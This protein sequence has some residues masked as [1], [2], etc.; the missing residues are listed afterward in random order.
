MWPPPTCPPCPDNKY[1][2]QQCTT[3]PRHTGK[4]LL[5]S[6][7][8]P[9]ILPSNLLRLCHCWV[10]LATL[11]FGVHHFF[12]AK[13]FLSYAICWPSDALTPCICFPNSCLSCRPA[14]CASVLT[15]S[16]FHGL[17]TAPSKEQGGFHNWQIFQKISQKQ[18]VCVGARCCS[19]SAKSYLSIL[20]T[21]NL[22]LDINLFQLFTGWQNKH[23][24]PVR[25]AVWNLSRARRQI[26]LST[27]PPLPLTRA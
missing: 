3:S 17:C 1:H 26:F 14:F 16:F 23:G 2:C 10:K 24:I 7:H 5:L 20:A 19:H 21:I 22:P 8:K 13:L 6:S 15:Q 25:E 4:P 9:N 11:L 27:P 12:F 18:F